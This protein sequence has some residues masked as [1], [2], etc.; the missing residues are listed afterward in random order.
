MTPKRQVVVYLDKAAASLRRLPRNVERQVRRKV[1]GLLSE[2][3]PPQAKRL[4]GLTDDG[5]PICRL[6]VARKYRVLYLARDNPREILVL[7]IDNR[8]KVYR[9]AKRRFGG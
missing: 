7:G 2:P 3:H 9:E 5:E 6:P 8:D 4:H 1:D